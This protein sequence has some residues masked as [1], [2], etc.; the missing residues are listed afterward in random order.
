M[1]PLPAQTVI[2]VTGLKR[3]AGLVASPSVRTV[4]GGGDAAGLSARLERALA[5]APAAGIVSIGIGGA[6][7]PGLQVGDWV[8]AGQVI[9]GAAR[10]PTDPRWRDALLSGAQGRRDVHAGDIAG[11][12]AMVVDARAKAALHRATGAV[13]VDMESHVAAAIAA[14]HA[15]P[16]AALR[17]ISDTSAQDLPKAVLA[18]MKPDGG[19][20]LPGVLMA[21]AADPR[22]LPAL[23]RTGREAETAFRGLLRSHD[24]FRGP[25]IGCP[26]LGQLL[27][28]VP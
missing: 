9:A 11:V 14:R 5:E 26:Y 21:L 4:V 8:V 13:A 27:L 3:E 16:F 6:L 10:Y 12:D 7:A 25:G 18:G 2:A 15:L 17:I 20:N 19:M 28:D 1:S 23:I 22:Q 24:L